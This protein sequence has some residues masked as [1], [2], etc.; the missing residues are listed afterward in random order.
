MTA[1]LVGEAFQHVPVP[2]L[3]SLTQ[4]TGKTLVNFATIFYVQAASFDTALTLLGQQVTL[5]VRPVSYA[6]DHGDGVVTTTT[7]P[8]APYPR[9]DVVYRYQKA[10]TTVRHHVSVTWAATFQV[11][12]GPAADVPG[13]VTTT[14]PDTALRVVEA[15]PVLVGDQ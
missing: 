13:T 5:H 6:W 7:G 3:A 4:P 8:G 14:G 1:P 2:H 9:K 12:G 11:N 10:T 15:T